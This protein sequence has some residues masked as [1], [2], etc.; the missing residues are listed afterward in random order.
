MK[1]TLIALL[2]F[3]GTLAKAELVKPN[4]I[5]YMAA[6]QKEI[7]QM[8]DSATVFPYEPLQNGWRLIHWVGYIKKTDIQGDT[9]LKTGSRLF[10]INSFEEEATLMRDVRPT[11]VTDLFGGNYPDKKKVVFY[12]FIPDEAIYQNSRMEWRMEQV[13]KA[14]KKDQTKA[15]DVFKKDFGFV[16]AI[17]IQDQYNLHFVYDTRSPEGANDFRLLVFTDS[18]GTI[19]AVAHE[20]YRPMKIKAKEK[21]SLDR[22]LNIY[23]VQKLPQEERQIIQEHFIEAYRF[24]DQ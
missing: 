2:L 8:D 5:A 6:G 15:F 18:A 20:D 14:K 22:K 9:L 23:Y 17:L 1:N 21:A 10:G 16:D 13:L 4:T 24:R 19:I 12:L 3:T 7:L 11:F